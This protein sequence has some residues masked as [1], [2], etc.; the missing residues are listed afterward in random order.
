MSAFQIYLASFGSL[1]LAIGVGMAVARA[2]LT[3]GG[4]ADGEIVGYVERMRSRRGAV[5][6]F[7]PKVRFHTLEGPQEFQSRMSGDPDRWPV[8][9]RVRV[10]YRR[11]KPEAAEIAQAGRLWI[12]PIVVSL[13]GSVMIGIA[14]SVD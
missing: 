4:R 8:G 3:A 1:V 6:Q 10:A 13:F 11:D 12:P 14:L 7:M 2:R 5:P 9:T